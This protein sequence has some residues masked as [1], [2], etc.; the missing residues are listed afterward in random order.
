MEEL[1]AKLFDIQAVKFGS[2]T[3]KSGLVSPIYFDLRVII[4]YPK[5][6]VTCTSLLSPYQLLNRCQSLQE[7]VSQLLWEKCADKSSAELLCGVPY[8]ALP[9]ATLISV[10]QG[11]PMLLRRKE[12]KDYGT[13][14]LIE[15]D[16]RPGQGCL[17][18]EDV[19][20]SGTSILETAVELRK[21]GLDVKEAVVL[22]DRKQGGSENLSKHGIVM[23]CVFHIEEVIQF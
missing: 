16:Y 1:A 7:R 5:I 2:F 17:I 21:L 14:K 12:A 8:T 22:L 11:I 23:S 13:K 6:L 18:V 4:S 10:T 15:G 3:L 19:V 20:T 9:M